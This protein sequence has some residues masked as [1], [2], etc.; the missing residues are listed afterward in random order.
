MNFFAQI[1][2]KI[3]TMVK[4][5]GFIEPQSQGLYKTFGFKAL[6]CPQCGWGFFY[7]SV[8]SLRVTVITGQTEGLKVGC[9]MGVWVGGGMSG[10]RHGWVC[11]SR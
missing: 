1:L 5:K 4:T 6:C 9:G 7:T 8:T 11:K 10:W 2:P 3:L